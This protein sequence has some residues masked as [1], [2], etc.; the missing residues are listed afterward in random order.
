M[1]VTPLRLTLVVVPALLLA[2]AVPALLGEA[3]TRQGRSEAPMAPSR[4]ELRNAPVDE[5]ALR[6][7]VATLAALPTRLTGSDGCR[8]AAAWVRARLEEIAPGNVRSETFAVTVPL[9]ERGALLVSAADGATLEL[10][11]YPLW[12]NLVRCNQTPPEGLHGPLLDAGAL[13]PARL[14][15]LPLRGGVVLADFN[16]GDRFLTV[17]DLG[18]SAVIFCAPAATTRGEA[19]DKFLSV[20]LNAPRYYLAAEHAAALRAR[21]AAGERLEARIVC[22]QRWRTVEAENLIAVLPGSDPNLAREVIALSAPYDSISVVPELAPGASQSGGLAALLALGRELAARPLPR[23]VWLVATAGHAQGLAGAR[24]LVRRHASSGVYGLPRLELRGPASSGPPELVLFV[25]LDFSSGSRQVLALRQGYWYDYDDDETDPYYRRMGA[26]LRATVDALAAAEGVAARDADLINALRPLPGSDW[27]ADL[28]CNP[29]FDAEAAVARGVY[30]LTLTT[31]RDIRPWLDTPLDRADNFDVGNLARQ[32]QVARVALW[33]VL[34]DPPSYHDQANPAL[35]GRWKDWTALVTLRLAESELEAGFLP[36]RKVPF[37]L[38]VARHAAKTVTGVRGDWIERA[39]DQGTAH[40]A[41]L[42]WPAMQDA[43]PARRFSAFLLSDH[44]GSIAMAPDLGMGARDFPGSID[45]AAP[46]AEL[47]LLLFSCRPTD[48]YNLVDPRFF[49]PLL[50][51]RLIDAR[52]ESEPLS[53]GFVTS[54]LPTQSWNPWL[55]DYL[56]RAQPV[57]VLF[58]APGA[59]FKATFSS[60]VFGPRL[61]LI[62]ADAANPK[63]TGWEAEATPRIVHGALTTGRDLTALNQSRLAVYERHGIE[64]A[65]TVAFH[66]GAQAALAE[67]EA[68]VARRDHAGALRWANAAWALSIRAYKETLA[69]AVDVLRGVLFYLFIL[70]PFS[71]FAERL[72]F[73]CSNIYARLGVSCGIFL[74]VF[75]G[76]AAVHPAFRLTTM[77]LV[78][79]LAFITLV[80]TVMVSAIIFRRFGDYLAELADRTRTGRAAGQ[81]TQPGTIFMVG[82]SNMNRRPA[83]TALTLFTITA[84]S[85]AALSFTGVTTRQ[86]ASGLRLGDGA[87]YTGVLL[88]HP[89]WG[90]LNASAADAFEHEFAGEAAVAPRYW[91]L[92]GQDG[93]ANFLVRGPGAERVYRMDGVLGVMP[94]ETRVS[95]LG[96]RLE[97]RMFASPDERA[98]ILPAA[99]ARALGIDLNAPEANIEVLGLRL[100]V[101]GILP[102]GREGEAAPLAAWRDLDGESLTPVRLAEIMAARVAQSGNRRQAAAFRHIEPETTL[103][104][105][106]GLVRGL[107]GRLQSIAVAF[108]PETDIAPRVEDLL[109]RKELSLYVG[110]DGQRLL[111]S[112][113]GST[114][115][116]GPAGLAVP[117]AIMFFIVLNTMLGAVYE[118]R[119]EIT[120]QSA[121]GLSPLHIAGLFIA[122]AC[123]YAVI[124][125]MAGYFI[126]QG[127][128]AFVHATGALPGLVP[129]YSSLGA[130]LSA[131]MVMLTVLVSTLYPAYQAARIATPGERAN[132]QFPAPQGDLLH[133]ELPFT[134]SS[135]ARGL[136]AFIAERLAEQQEGHGGEFI[137]EQVAVDEANG[138]IRVTAA[139]WLAPFDLGVSQRFTLTLA[140]FEGEEIRIAILDLE[141]RSG[142]HEAWCRLN[143]RFLHSLRKQ[144]LQWR[145]FSDRVRDRYEHGELVLH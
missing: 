107:G 122:E 80:L 26:R 138:D 74:A 38:G 57:A 34:E 95:G 30:G 117:L 22:D 109:M 28:G 3:W 123:V 133:A 130:V 42:G 101:V 134:A 9:T 124:G 54:E 81:L 145:S 86:Q 110:R 87:A 143:R 92:P 37:G 129:N 98:A 115:Y 65:R 66:R 27:R 144:F 63:G 44:D 36:S 13:E 90:P 5:G 84:L 71:I 93:R 18:A 1:N 105:P 50:G 24:D 23:P 68:A 41:G 106:A 51:V 126:G 88:R 140:P 77:P 121:V 21:L 6:D 12:P 64:D 139:V 72:F 104:L 99:A 58:N 76:L 56:T 108:A 4:V 39:D 29:G 112:S 25:G 78:V 89:E 137:A 132:W 131:M 128:A 45:I 97:G 8:H 19:E 67:A 118:R 33:D 83:R 31:A 125:N 116:H 73:G 96:G 91:L 48:V 55:A 102:A 43:M 11:L 79:L 119:R 61:L 35:A 127:V 16:S 135:H 113:V 49:G 120:I 59:R 46:Q 82:V 47:T 85:F 100:R 14:S 10:P 94:E 111:Y 52:T 69:V 40:F 7:A 136:A 114:T 70:I 32:V 75:L 62:N 17:F 15:G 142:E 103:I 141:R 2:A 60:G 20:P 53:F